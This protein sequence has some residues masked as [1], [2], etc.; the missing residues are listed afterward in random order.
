VARVGRLAR[1]EL[2]E[3][4]RDRRT[5]LTLV[6]MP[7]I[8]YP[9]LSFAF[10]QFLVAF[11]SS[12]PPSTKYRIGVR[13]ER[14]KTLLTKFLMLGAEVEPWRL[15]QMAGVAAPSFAPG[16]LLSGTQFYAGRTFQ[17]PAV[18][19]P[20]ANPRTGVRTYPVVEIVLLGDRLLVAKFHDEVDV[21]LR[22]PD[23]PDAKVL[24]PTEFEITYPEQLPHSREVAAFVDQHIAR[25]NARELQV[26][27][28]RDG[29]PRELAVPVRMITAPL[30]VD[31]SGPNL[32][33]TA[34]VPLILILMTITGAVYPAIDLTAGE[35]ERGTLEILVAAPVPRLALLL[36]K[37][38][39][40]VVVAMLTATVNL[41]MMLLTLE[42]NGLTMEVFKQHGITVSLVVQL[43]FLLILFAAFFS[44][45]LL[46]LTSFARSFK[47]A[48]AY[49]IPLM[50]VSL[51]PGVIGMMPDLH[52]TGPLMVMPL[53]NIVLLARDLSEGHASAGTSA[54]V[55]VSTLVYAAAAITAAARVFGAEAVLFSE[56]SGW[57]DLFR[58][59]KRPEATAT[60]SGALICMALLFPVYFVASSLT[61]SFSFGV[62]LYFLG[63]ATVL[64]FAGFPL[65]AC[66]LARIRPV[67]SLNLRPPP[68]AAGAAGL[69]LAFAAVPAMY[70][71]IGWL[72]SW[73]WVMLNFQQE[74]MHL[75]DLRR[76]RAVYEPW[77]VVAVLGMVG[78]AEELFFRGFLFSALR[79]STG[80][81][82]TI[83]GTGVLFGLFHFVSQFD[84]LLPSTLLGLLL[85]WVCW[86]TR[87]VLPG[88]VLHG[89]YNGLVALLLFGQPAPPGPGSP[90]SP[91]GGS[92]L[93]IPLAW[94][95][96]AGP[97]GL[98][99]LGAIWWFRVPDPAP[100]E[101][102]VL[103]ELDE[104]E[105]GDSEDAAMREDN[106]PRAPH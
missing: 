44:A 63:L 32:S 23:G 15:G 2:S 37:Y 94:L 56:Q 68:P 41:T 24:L 75:E 14:E 43:L 66:M 59:P 11:A 72:Q 74:R 31:D 55:V 69:L 73:G 22:F 13:G 105:E 1:K 92:L 29:L 19:L 6:L 8:L 50:L 30:A 25:L 60:V 78:I 33:L 62:R 57:S 7:L 85:G 100:A 26:L 36:A 89:T 67:S 95:I 97:A 65:V 3:I 82:A 42:L 83:L 40:V 104:A 96:A 35:R 21:I 103:A 27:L 34:L 79:A 86:Q 9:L 38:V 102:V 52:L 16:P 88:M 46:V 87:S 84:R 45:V 5:I 53:V 90:A 80:R 98:L 10:R 81:T 17:D 93:E 101:E 12:Q 58:R 61:P 70:V 106:A 49:L 28:A 77:E 20:P 64:M 54:V 76:L 47:E 91:G 48:Q 39:A 71:F 4:L 99:A 51:A 18:P